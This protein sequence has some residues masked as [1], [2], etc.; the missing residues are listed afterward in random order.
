MRGRHPATERQRLQSLLRK[1][2]AGAGLTQI[3]MA[4]RLGRPQSYVSKYESGERALELCEI[5]EICTAAGVDLVEFAK[6][7]KR[8]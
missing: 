1:I 8:G 4:K 3:A 6:R 5:D 2:R 7:Y